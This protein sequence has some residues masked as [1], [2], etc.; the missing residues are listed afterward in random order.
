MCLYTVAKKSLSSW[1]ASLLSQY[2]LVGPTARRDN[3]VFAE[4]TDAS[5]LSLDYTTTMLPPKKYLLPLRETLI[6]F[7]K[8]THGTKVT[9]IFDNRAT[10]IFGMHTCDLHAVRLLDRFF[11]QG[12]AD[13]TYLRR[14]AATT[15]VS[16]E[17]LQPCSPL[18]FCKSMGTYTIQEEFDLHLTDIGNVYVCEVGSDKGAALI[19]LC[20]DAR[21]TKGSEIIEMNRMLSEKWG[22][23]P[24]LLHADLH[25]L[26][27]MMTLSYESHLW[28]EL[29]E[30][31]MGCGVCN[32]VCPTCYCFDVVDEIEL[33]LQHGERYRIWDS[34]QSDAFAVVAGGHNFRSERAERLRHRFMRKGKY[35]FES[36]GLP[37]CV[38]CGRCAQ[39]CL[40]DISP[41]DVFN[42]L[43][44]DVLP[45]VAVN[46]EVER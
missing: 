42:Q 16:I 45:S 28:Q 33:D 1:F 21:Q 35:Q 39:S 32:I 23:F 29:G 41:L 24:D 15:I 7:E 44:H 5:R 4:I 19:D 8:G 27:S 31:C 17:C 18:S 20:P 2:Y 9:P 12:V 46:E 14:R 11:E 43:H 26:P 38:G 36:L 34:C 25:A 30:R 13:Q 10:V 40:A 22:R 37:G 3:F 6:Q